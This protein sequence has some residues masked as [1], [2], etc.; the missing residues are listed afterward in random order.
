MLLPYKITAL[1]IWFLLTC[2]SYWDQSGKMLLFGLCFG[3]GIWTNGFKP[4]P[5]ETPCVTVILFGTFALICA[6]LTIGFQL[7][8]HSWLNAF[9]MIG[10][11]ATVILGR[12]NANALEIAS[13]EDAS[14]V[15][16]CKPA[17]E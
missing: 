17:D 3:I 11:F 6:S 15:G 13:D 7:T 4:Y 5:G 14:P 1:A 8:D 2:C 9:L 10:L 16:D 12:C